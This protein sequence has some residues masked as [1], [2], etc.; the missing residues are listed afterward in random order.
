MPD[1]SGM[2]GKV[3]DMIGSGKKTA[4]IAMLNLPGSFTSINLL[5]LQ[6]A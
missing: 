4:M 2:A 6:Q 3:W 1:N 5:Q